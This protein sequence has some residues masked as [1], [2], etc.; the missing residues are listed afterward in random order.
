MKMK[1]MKQLAVLIGTGLS[2]SLTSDD[3]LPLPN[4]P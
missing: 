4:M 1:G 2:L 3:A